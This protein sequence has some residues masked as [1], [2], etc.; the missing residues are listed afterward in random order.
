MVPP[1]LLLVSP[2]ASL[3]VAGHSDKQELEHKPK[4]CHLLEGLSAPH[5]PPVHLALLALQ[6]RKLGP[7]EVWTDHSGHPGSR[8]CSA[9]IGLSPKLP[10]THHSRGC[11][12]FG[13][14]CLG[15]RP[16]QPPSVPPSPGGK[17]SSCLRPMV[18]LRLSPPQILTP[19]RGEV[20]LPPKKRARPLCAPHLLYRE[21]GAP[22]APRA[23]GTA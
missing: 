14:V 18:M 6:M 2:H 9:A 15:L 4:A 11:R 16:W 22:T 10:Q 17:G 20:P 3:P 5:A 23:G 7:R 19:I 1:T 8:S 12:E 21:T 13:W